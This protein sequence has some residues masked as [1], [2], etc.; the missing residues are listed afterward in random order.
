VS[1][2]DPIIE[3]EKVALTRN[4]KEIL[5]NISWKV[6]YNENW[7]LFGRNGSG[8]TML[9]EVIAGYLYPTMG[10]IRRFGKGYGE[11]VT[12][13]EMRQRIGYVSTPLKNMF[14]Q[15]ERVI[16]VIIS[17]IYAGIGLWCEPKPDEREKAR[18][19]LSIIHMEHRA[20]DFFGILSD[21]EK[22]KILMMRALINEPHLMLLD[23]PVQSLD[24]PSRE[25]VLTSIENIHNLHG[26]SIIYVTHHTE[27]ITP[28]FNHVLILENGGILYRGQVKDGLQSENLQKIF[29]H[30]LNVVTL[31]NRYY[32]ILT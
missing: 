7:V 32:T 16:D 10:E 13:T 1:N 20:D 28:L 9:L 29:N 23:E 31:N 26:T 27:E 24:I 17:G 3:L 15:R 21:G 6:K 18:Y 5:R 30:S 22:Q 4:E 8:K 14:H 19:L 25:D 12:I 11:G 2:D